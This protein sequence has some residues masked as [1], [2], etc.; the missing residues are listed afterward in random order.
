MIKRCTVYR[1]ADI[2]GKRWTL[3]ILLTL[4]KGSGR[5]RYSEIKKCIPMITP[6]MLSGRLKELEHN[7]IIKK[8][9]KDDHM[10]ISTYYSLTRKGT[11][12]IKVILNLKKWGLEWHL[13]AKQCDETLCKFCDS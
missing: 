2:I 9:I 7:G 5:K 6:K 13:G 8:E 11:G 1:A 3:V 12:L 10:P 4:S